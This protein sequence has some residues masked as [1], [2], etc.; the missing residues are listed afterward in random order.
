LNNKE[1]NHTVLGNNNSNFIHCHNTRVTTLDDDGAG[2]SHSIRTH[3]SGSRRC[4][5]SLS[6][7]ILILHASPIRPRFDHHQINHQV[8]IQPVLI[9]NSSQIFLLFQFDPK[10]SFRH[11]LVIP[12][13][14]YS[15][16]IC[17]GLK[18]R[19]FFVVLLFGV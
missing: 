10:P 16:T 4:R 5:R 15:L 13:R 3:T 12:T 14:L 17:V 2:H 11:D 19:R 9:L 18:R 1:E 8:F 7:P 6:I